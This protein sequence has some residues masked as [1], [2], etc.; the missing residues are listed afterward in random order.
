MTYVPASLRDPSEVARFWA[1]VSIPDNMDG[2]WVWTASGA[3]GYG[4]F[5]PGRPGTYAHRYSYELAKGP[6]PDGY[7]VDHLCRNKGCVNP[8]H[9]EAVTP[10]VNVLRSTSFAAREARVTHCP[11]GHAYD[12]NNT[13]IV[14]RE[15]QRPKRQCRRCKAITQRAYKARLREREAA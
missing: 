4:L 1:K 2:C 10:Q 7:Q 9:L 3:R 8:S 14:R 13:Y 6:I 12:E 11:R 15:G 5:Y